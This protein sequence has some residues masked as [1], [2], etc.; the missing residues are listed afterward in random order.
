MKPKEYTVLT[1]P[2]FVELAGNY[3]DTLGWIFRGQGRNLDEWPLI[4]KAG[5]AEFLSPATSVWKERGETTND[6]GRFH[7]WREQAVAFCEYLPENDFECL[8][9]AQHYGLATRLLDWTKNPLVALFFAVECDLDKDGVVCCHR[10]DWYVNRDGMKLVGCDCVACLVPR[11]FDRRIQSQNGVFTFHPTPNEPL[12]PKEVNPKDSVA[13][14]DGMDLVT[15][16]IPA[17]MKDILLRQLS[18]VGISR[19]N[20]FPDLEGL[21]DFIN[22]ETSSRIRSR[23]KRAKKK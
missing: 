1:L 15:I 14:P 12:A 2:Q 10:P 8:A 7:A 19:K 11:P 3:W 20:L 17:E 13:I 18:T 22:W 6:L 4:P 21:S 9:Y 16:R 5:R 23:Q